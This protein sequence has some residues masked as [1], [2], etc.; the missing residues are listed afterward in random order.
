MKPSF[1]IY[2]CLFAAFT[3]NCHAIEQSASLNN[4]ELTQPEK[5]QPQQ[6]ALDFCVY[7]RLVLSVS[8]II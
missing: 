7:C 8:L 4:A 2:A 6:D 5:V 3:L 1:I